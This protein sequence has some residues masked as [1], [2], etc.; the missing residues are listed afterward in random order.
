MKQHLVE[1]FRL[2]I[3]LVSLLKTL[4]LKGDLTLKQRGMR[5]QWAQPWAVAQHHRTWAIATLPLAAGVMVGVTSDQPSTVMAQANPHVIYLDRLSDCQLASSPPVPLPIVTG[6]TATSRITGW[7]DG[8]CV[9][10]TTVARTDNPERQSLLAI[11]RYTPATLSLL[12][13]D[14]AYEAA[15]AGNYDFNPSNAQ[16]AAIAEAMGRECQFFQDWYNELSRAS[17]AS[18]FDMA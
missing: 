1:I 11:C 17:V 12:T 6:F 10:E 3:G 7:V 4:S 16:D 9:I 18:G 5:W 14:R 2:A 13:S 15:R 8:R